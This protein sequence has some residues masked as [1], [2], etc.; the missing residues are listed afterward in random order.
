MIFHASNSLYAL[1]SKFGG[2][3]AGSQVKAFTKELTS[4]E[5]TVDGDDLVSMVLYASGS[6]YA[7]I[8]KSGGGV[9]LQ[10]K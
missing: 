5:S 10:K 1:I 4:D 9:R 6:L 3:L 8:S 7:F 2:S